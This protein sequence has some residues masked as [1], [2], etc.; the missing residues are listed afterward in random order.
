MTAAAI[1]DPSHPAG[2]TGIGAAVDTGLI[3][4]AIGRLALGAASRLAPGA[5]A[6][7]FGAG[8]ART[9]EL[10]YVTR[11]FGIRAIAL[12]LGYLS[13]TGDGRRR[14]QR[15]AFLCDISDTIAG[16]GDLLRGE[17]RRSSA[18]RATLLTGAY[19]VIGAARIARDRV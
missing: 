4:M 19:A 18:V 1:E 15:L 3:A 11:V 14:W 5:T 12:G 9:P 10:D 13:T 17:V 6:R 2:P 7:A 8:A 16:A